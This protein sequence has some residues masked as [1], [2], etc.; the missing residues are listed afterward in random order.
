MLAKSIN[1]FSILVMAVLFFS[2]EKKQ[3]HLSS[4]QYISF[5]EKRDNGFIKEKKIGNLKFALR[6]EP[7]DY[8]AS[9][10]IEKGSIKNQQQLVEFR[11]K[12]EGLN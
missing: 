3:E 5:V 10:H 1:I 2:C 12:R 9:I 7:T 4:R 8:T 11:K 6:Y